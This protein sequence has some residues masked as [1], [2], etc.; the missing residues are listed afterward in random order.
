MTAIK[1]SVDIIRSHPERIH[2]KDVKKLTAVASATS[3]M[4]QLIEDLLFLARTDKEIIVPTREKT[5]LSLKFLLQNLVVL[6]E[7][8]AQ[9]KKIALKAQLTEETIIFGEESKIS[10]LL[11]N[12]IHNAIQYTP[13]GGTISI[14]LYKQNRFALIKIKDT[15]IGIAEEQLPYIF[16]RFW[17]A[18]KARSRREG[19][20]GLGLAIA[21]AIAKSHGGK[22]NVSSKVNAGS[23]FQ[24]RLPLLNRPSIPNKH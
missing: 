16:D 21:Q 1:F 13:E 4:G 2:P 9:N 24:V 11:S 20:T 5:N 15:G 18:D 19:G 8:V 12:L 6:L 23:C 22:I 3:Q 14:E 10:R 7:P 17:R